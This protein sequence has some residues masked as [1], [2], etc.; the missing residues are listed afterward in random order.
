MKD[1]NVCGGGGSCKVNSGFA[2]AYEE[3]K[4]AMY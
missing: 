3:V 1:W 2:D 4:W